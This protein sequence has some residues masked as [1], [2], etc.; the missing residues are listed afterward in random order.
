MYSIGE[1][2]KICNIPIK[3][4]RYYNDIDLLLPSYIDP[5]TNYRYYDYDKIQ[6]VKTIMLLKSCQFSLSSIKQLIETADQVNWEI[7]LEQKMNEL[8]DQK[9]QISK[10]LKQL[11]ELKIKMEEENLLVS[12]SFLSDCY[13]EQRDE[14]IVY[15]LRKKINIKFIDNLVKSLFERVYA[16]HLKING[17]LMAVFHE[18]NLVQEEVDIE[19]LIPIKESSEIEG[20]R[21]LKG[22]L[23]ACITVKG[24]YSELEMGYKVLENWIKEQNMTQLEKGI[25]IYEKGLISPSFSIRNIKPDLNR[26]PAEFITKICILID[27]NMII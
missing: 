10:Q 2:S 24:P 18:I 20:C 16:F 15:T 1:F 6:A 8:E 11:S 27:E 23:Y 19:L 22:G 14:M 12:G 9:R 21:T 7:V 4:L 5:Q 26:H 13:V 17:K 25:E 3:T